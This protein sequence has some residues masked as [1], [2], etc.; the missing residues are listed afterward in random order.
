MCAINPTYK[1]R[2]IFDF[3]TARH[4]IPRREFE[5]MIIEFCLNKEQEI[6]VAGILRC[7]VKE[8]TQEAE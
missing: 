5:K 6:N 7:H 8:T 1:K 2:I 3:Y 4:D